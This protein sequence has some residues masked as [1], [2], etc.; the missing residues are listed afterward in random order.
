MEEVGTQK[1]Q[2]KSLSASCDGVKY[3]SVSSSMLQNNSQH[4]HVF[5]HT[6]WLP[7]PALFFPF[8]CT[9]KAE[10]QPLCKQDNKLS[11]ANARKI[12]APTHKAIPLLVRDRKKRL[13]T[14]HEYLIES[15]Q[16]CLCRTDKIIVWPTNE[17]V[18]KFHSSYFLLTPKQ[19]KL[20]K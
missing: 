16:C 7:V 15:V 8:P 9:G 5:L 11:L 19:T 6:P 4:V 17:L 18:T 14:R 1:M 2:C 12:V 3:S 10:K 20:I 13:E